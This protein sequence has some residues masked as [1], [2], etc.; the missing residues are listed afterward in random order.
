[1][2]D[3]WTDI[4]RDEP[5]ERFEAA[6]DAVIA[7][8]AP[9]FAFVT[10]AQTKASYVDRMDI[11]ASTI[12]SMVE[13]ATRHDPL[14]FA[15]VHEAILTQWEADFDAIQHVRSIDAQRTSAKRPW[16]RR[17]RREAGRKTAATV[18]NRTPWDGLTYDPAAPD[19]E[20]GRRSVWTVDVLGKGGGN[21]LLTLEFKWPDYTVRADPYPGGIVAKGQTATLMTI[22]SAAI[23]FLKTVTPEWWEEQ[24]AAAVAKYSS[25]TAAPVWVQNQSGIGP[26][27][28]WKFWVGRGYTGMPGSKIL[29]VTPT[30][31]YMMNGPM[32]GEAFA[33]FEVQ[34]ADGR[35]VEIPRDMFA[36]WRSQQS[37]YVP[38]T[39]MTANG[40]V[41]ITA[42]EAK[43]LVTRFPEGLKERVAA[44]V[45]LTVYGPT[46]DRGVTDNL[47]TAARTSGDDQEWWLRN[48]EAQATVARGGEWLRPIHP[49]SQGEQGRMFDAKLAGQYPDD[50]DVNQELFDEVGD[51]IWAE[52]GPVEVLNPANVTIGTYPTVADA[53][54]WMLDSDK[55]GQYTTPDDYYRAGYQVVVVPKTASKT[56]AVFTTPEENAANPPDTWIVEKVADRLWAL[57]TKDGVTF[58]NYPTRA[59]AEAAKSSG[60]LFD[61]YNKEKRWYAGEQFPNLRSWEDVKAEQERTKA[62]FG[63]QST[64]AV[65]SYNIANIPSGGKEIYSANGVFC[66]VYY[67]GDNIR[68]D[69]GALVQGSGVW[70]VVVKDTDEL[71]GGRQLNRKEFRCQEGKNHGIVASMVA[72]YVSD[73]LISAKRRQGSKGHGFEQVAVDLETNA[74][75]TGTYRQG[76]VAAAVTFVRLGTAV[77]WAVTDEAGDEEKDSGSTPSVRDALEQAWD[78]L[79]KVLDKQPPPSADIVKE[80]TDAV[81]ATSDAVTE[82]GGKAPEEKAA[83]TGKPVADQSKAPVHPADPQPK[84]GAPVPKKD[85]KVVKPDA[86]IDD[87]KTAPADVKAK[88]DAAPVA[89]VPPKEP[90]DAQGPEEESTEAK[91]AD[92]APPASDKTAPT[93][94]PGAAPMPD[95]ATS[96]DS[97]APNAIVDKAE[98]LSQGDV[99]GVDPSK[100]E[101]GERTSMTY[102]LADGTTGTV[103]VTF[104]REENEIYFFDGPQGEFGIGERDDQWVDADGN[105]F[106][107]SQGDAVDELKPEQDQIDLD[108][109]AYE[110]GT[111]APPA[112]GQS[113][114]DGKPDFIK[115]KADGGGDDK[116]GDAPAD[117]K[118]PAKDDSKGDDSTDDDGKKKKSAPPWA[119]AKES[120]LAENPGLSPGLAD[121]LAKRAFSLSLHMG[122][123]S[124]EDLRDA[125]YAI[126]RAL[127]DPN[128]PDRDPELLEIRDKIWDLRRKLDPS[129]RD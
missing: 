68:D 17:Q 94:D 62:R 39:S 41:A 110:E 66:H 101:T 2:T 123:I 19:S 30:E 20:R 10:E 71:V 49:R 24:K 114:D 129:L 37:S 58:E 95:N 127:G 18:I 107:F 84:D 47:L 125:M 126:N 88:D 54:K 4:I 55:F 109:P 79:N 97:G 111:G 60:F 15:P 26:D 121:R 108:A 118:A 53:E 100:M 99:S 25:K 80:V 22:E 46:Y 52:S 124:E 28:D 7:A 116:K 70:E 61:L 81:D 8:L 115:D 59:A 106:A 112:E 23:D 50:Y 122:A 1:M 32:N 117:D 103:D 13:A 82:A 98:D 14:L 57:K 29:S 40:K 67:D 27:F 11:V 77:H 113:G 35:V 104:L 120:I 44:I 9:K 85:D 64:D 73:T 75:V 21:M 33:I 38:K 91:P 5:R 86:P 65:L 3:L 6:L 102:T 69:Y 72:D 87:G 36:M 48:A 56:A 74:I 128:D 119:K 96:P 78:A 43:E 93:A 51:M 92:G 90:K 76:S 89:A 12:E 34:L 83:D 31:D 45:E 63:S 105:S 16:Y 42:S